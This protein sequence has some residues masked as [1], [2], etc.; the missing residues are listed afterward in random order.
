MSLSCFFKKDV[1]TSEKKIYV[2]IKREVLF[3]FAKGHGNSR[4]KVLS[5]LYS[6]HLGRICYRVHVLYE[7]SSSLQCAVRH[8]AC[9][10]FV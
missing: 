7:V 5:M 4:P 1:T 8:L 9:A 6:F 10:C 3:F 2:P